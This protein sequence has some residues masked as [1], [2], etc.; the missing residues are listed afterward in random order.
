MMRHRHQELRRGR[1]GRYVPLVVPA[2]LGPLDAAGQVVGAVQGHGLA[3]TEPG[4]HVRI[5]LRSRNC[6]IRQGEELFRTTAEVALEEQAGLSGTVGDLA[7]V[8]VA[9]A[10]QHCLT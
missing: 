4:P 6:P 3:E 10:R 7:V 1:T 5:L 2:A 8:A 9:E